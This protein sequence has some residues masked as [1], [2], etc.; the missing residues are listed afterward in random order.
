[1]QKLIK[2]L[3]LLLFFI[4]NLNAAR[5]Y[6]DSEGGNDGNSGTDSTQ[7]WKTITQVNS[8]SSYP[9]FTPGDII[10]FKCGQIFQGTTLI[11]QNSGSEGLPII[12]NSYGT[13]ARPILDGNST[14]LCVDVDTKSYINFIGLKF[15]HGYRGDSTYPS[16]N[17]NLWKC[18]HITVESCNIDSSVGGDIHKVNLYDGQGS[19]LTVRNCTLN[20]GEQATGNGNLGIYLDGTDNSL[21][22]YDTLIGNFS[23]V[24]LAFGDDHGMANNDTIRYCVIKG[25]RYDNVDD[26]GSSGA[27]FYYNQFETNN[28]NIYFFTDGS[29]SY[30]SYAP[31]NSF[32]YNNT[33]ITTGSE[34]SIHTLSKTATFN[35]MVFKNNINYLTTGSGFFVY[36]EIDS[37]TNNYSMGNFTLNYN[38][39]FVTTDNTHWFSKHGT[40]YPNL[41]SWYGLGYDGNSKSSDP[42][43][44][45]TNN[46]DYSLQNGSPAVLSGVS[47]G[48][49]QDIVG[50]TVADPPDIG[51]YQNSNYISGFL[52]STTLSG[53]VAV[54]NDVVVPSGNTVTIS[55]GTHIKV[56]NYTSITIYGTLNC[57]YNSQQGDITFDL[58]PNYESLEGDTIWFM[59]FYGSSSS[60]SILQHASI[61]HNYRT[62]CLVGADV[63]I[64]NCN[65]LNSTEGIYIYDASPSIINNTIYDPVEN[66]IWCQSGLWATN[67][68]TISNNTIIKNPINAN[69]H[70]GQGIWIEDLEFSSVGANIVKGFENGILAGES[71]TIY[72]LDY[73]GYNPNRNNLIIDNICGLN[74]ELGSIIFAGSYID[75]IGMNNSIHNNISSDMN[76]F[77]GSLIEAWDNYWGGSGPT[78]MSFDGTST[79]AYYDEYLFSDPW[80]NQNLSAVKPA[81]NPKSVKH[82]N[83]SAGSV[84]NSNDSPSN[85]L[86]LENQG[87]IDDAISFYK[88]LISNDQYVRIALSQLVNIRFKYS[89]NELLNYLDSLLTIDQKYYPLIKKLLGDIS[90]KNNQFD[91]AM[92][93]YDNVIKIDPSGYDGISA[94]FEKLFAYLHFKKDQGTASA[95]LSD[96]K[97]IN[98]KDEYVQMKIKSTEDLIKC[99]N[100]QAYKKLISKD[101]SIPQS[102]D[103]SQNYPNPFNPS[104]TIR[105]QIPKQGLVTLKV[106]DI[107][108]REVTTLVNENKIEGF[109]TVKFNAS[110]FPSGVYIYQLRVND[111]VS[112]KKMILLK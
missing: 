71:A 49:T 22:E 27:I 61:N 88:G 39:Y 64:T 25:G 52:S 13:S 23:N 21:M 106:Y 98:S 67:F 10:S 91:D 85:G 93:S 24:R 3:I 54:T 63:N 20:Y 57:G 26:D 28:I 83:Q 86:F 50:K 94:R 31:R 108:G 110:K 92:S 79:I 8:F 2:F 41:A 19:Y 34:A 46:H 59:V 95:I 87:K 74:A 112:S 75:N 111:Y 7:A 38:L 15:I 35:G 37:S 42:Q 69:Y 101:A 102:Y 16:S 9:G 51:T 44:R 97:E 40:P 56:K 14:V 104:T 109:Y 4:G 103:L 18:S 68:S 66:G 47:V 100:G 48:L 90:L 70:S 32:Y 60:R 80:D 11:P 78:N 73:L 17:V 5:Y 33:F 55:V 36:D 1:M 96:I 62:L 65:F 6:V 76:C 82:M 12:F 72:C 107:I 81:N 77:E 43:F 45:D 89:R 105:Y 84:S 53:N 30:D 29:G 58:Y 99:S